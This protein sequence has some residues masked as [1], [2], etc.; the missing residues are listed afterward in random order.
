MSVD[1]RVV[2]LNFDNK[3]FEQA[4][5]E[6]LASLKKLDSALN[7]VNAGKSLSSIAISGQEADSQMASIAQGVDS[8][9]NRFSTLGIIGATALVKIT[10]SAMDLL[11]KIGSLSKNSIIQGGLTRALNIEQAEFLFE[12]LGISVQKAMTS[13]NKAVD[14]TAYSLDEAAKVGASFAA[15][16]IKAGKPLE[17]ALK[18]V[19]GMAA[20]TGSS[21]QDIGNIM[22]TIAGNGRLMGDD[23]LQLASRG[24]NVAALMGKQMNVTEAEFRDKV[25][26]GEITFAKFS[27][28]VEKQFAD[29]AKKA[30][31][32]FNGAFSNLKTSLAR[33]GAAFFGGISNSFYVVPEESVGALENLR[34]IFV[35][36][37][38]SINN[39]NKA[40]SPFIMAFNTRLT[41]ITDKVVV[42]LG[43]LEKVTG[44]IAEKSDGVKEFFSAF[45]EVKEL[46]SLWDNLTKSVDKNGNVTEEALDKFSKAG[47]NMY[48]IL[49]KAMGK[50]EEKIRTMAKNGKLSLD[51]V[52]T[53]L[54]DT[55]GETGLQKMYPGFIKSLKGTS[56]G[57][58]KMKSS[59]T[60]MDKFQNILAGIKGLFSI[61]A[62]VGS[63]ALR[64]LS[65]L[66]NL[67]LSVASGA[68]LFVSAISKANTV[69][70]I[71]DSIIDH[72]VNLINGLTKSLDSVLANIDKVFSFVGKTIGSA[73]SFVSSQLKNASVMFAAFGAA[74]TGGFIYVLKRMGD[75]LK[76]FTRLLEG[77]FTTGIPLLDALRGVLLS[78]QTNLKADTLKKIAIAVGILAGSL[79]LL[80]T[81]PL[82]KMAIA[83][84]GLTGLALLLMAFFGYFDKIQK[85]STTGKTS[86]ILASTKNFAS[87]SIALIGIAA[88]L[89]IMAS[90]LKSIAELNLDQL[91]VGITGL[92]AI[93]FMLEY[94]AKTIST[95]QGDMIRAGASILLMS[96][97][98]R[99]IADAVSVLGGLNLNQLAV[100]LTGLLGIVMALSIF[101]NNTESFNLTSAAG[102]LLI[103]SGIRIMADA[104]AV[105][106]GLDIRIIA[107]G[108]LTM[109][110][111]LAAIAGFSKLV[112][113]IGL[114][115]GSMLASGGSII[116]IAVGLRILASAL[117]VISGIKDVAKPL[118]AIGYS[119]L[120]M[121]MASEAMAGSLG[122]AAAILAIASA[123][124]I[125]APA[126][127]LLGSNIETTAKGLLVVAG[128]LVIFAGVAAM[129][130]PLEGVL[131]GIALAFLAFGGSI[132]LIGAG[133]LMLS[134][135]IL[136]LATAISTL[137]SV[138]IGAIDTILAMIGSF[139]TGIGSMVAQIAKVLV[140]GIVALGQALIAKSGDII[141]IA[142]DLIG[143]LIEGIVNNIPKLIDAGVQIITT[144][145]EGLSENISNIAFLG[146]KIISEFING[147][148]QNIPQIIQSGINLMLS[149][150]NG[151]ADGIRNNAEA[152]RGAIW[153]LCTAIL[154]AFCSFFGIAS[155]SKVMDQQGQNLIL[156]L[157]RGIGKH[158]KDVPKKILN[159]IKNIPGK[160]KEKA[161]QFLS[162][163][164]NIIEGLLK[165][166]G[167]K[168][169]KIKGKITDGID[170]AK[171]KLKN[172]SLYSH[173]QNIVQGFVNGLNSIKDKVS[174]FWNWLCDKA[175]AI[176]TKKNEIQ[177]PSKL[178]FRYGKYIMQG[179]INGL[180]S[181]KNKPIDALSTLS[182][183]MYSSL[184]EMDFDSTFSP[185]ITPVVDLSEVNAAAGVIDSSF[186]KRHA[187][188]INSAFS[189][190]VSS[191]E[192]LSKS[193]VDGL[194]KVLDNQVPSNTYIVDGVTYD[195]GSNIVNA[196]GE[197]VRAVKI[198]RRT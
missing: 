180:E 158:I 67:L 26:K 22:T 78:Y 83:F 190:R 100:A 124:A 148:S 60:G 87:A 171:K 102:I 57:F 34:K 169:D 132:A 135:G 159:G 28:F 99:I 85:I 65:S 27:K 20:V 31:E 186:S 25:S 15:T 98:I 5:A 6:T 137:A 40:L 11:A 50:S 191:E 179:L 182:D 173:G 13:A 127:V 141:K 112:S 198:E 64:I 152:V 115:A 82:D 17:N 35:A 104:V 1:S 36:L 19:A 111:A 163:G 119:L 144:F 101:T 185:V 165:G 84:A 145:L 63:A 54:A 62:T 14:Q 107:K 4:V 76:S 193:I 48:S 194:K 118:A 68:G 130:A 2:S 51:D 74:G 164:K 53:V 92:L 29:Q 162:S 195:D 146:A 61:F 32:T 109:A 197:L 69:G 125:L 42:S 154:E 81:I 105:L 49:G 86:D 93:T 97:G 33:I 136:L 176:V 175:S 46:P 12:G 181:L 196:V 73:L 72:I 8:L 52:K 139:I 161:G 43:K 172:T 108:M 166:L 156:G 23:L 47:I 116:L 71:F 113:K 183:A 56:D 38:P 21:F 123:L 189:S 90:A 39:V 9:S 59:L 157:L 121:A 170:A 44:K 94:L 16:G 80:S 120:I 70:S 96:F 24:I 168:K 184:D 192:T 58:K 103:C 122:G 89:L 160:I 114:G 140:D 18:G 7:T 110:A 37:M 129:L 131:M 149:F 77:K 177:S 151:L 55:F 126:L 45:S 91:A 41:T 128:A 30:N 88:S 95:L 138:G 75:S 167:D 143:M 79:F 153:N 134:G 188:S 133:I 106:G 147:V 3:Q 174:Q 178:Y 66:G 155:P 150:I 117:K 142:S 187:M 10:N